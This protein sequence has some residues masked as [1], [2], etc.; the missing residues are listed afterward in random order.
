MKLLIN[1]QVS[2]G[3]KIHYLFKLLQSP[4]NMTKK[5]KTTQLYEYETKTQRTIYRT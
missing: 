4:Q 2:K 5:R 1:V 3:K